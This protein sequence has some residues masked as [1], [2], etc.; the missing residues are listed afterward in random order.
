M[1]SPL[2]LPWA[3]KG[4]RKAVPA[5]KNEALERETNMAAGFA[6]VAGEGA[7]HWS[8]R[9]YAAWRGQAS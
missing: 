6:I 9:S 3:S 5:E 2:Q 7:A 8:G 4:G 1:K